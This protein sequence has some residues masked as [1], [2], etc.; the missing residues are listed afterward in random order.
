MTKSV[1]T[2]KKPR[3]QHFPEFRRE[4]LKLAEHIGVAAVTQKLSLYES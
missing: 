1:S 3:K 2:S 4:A